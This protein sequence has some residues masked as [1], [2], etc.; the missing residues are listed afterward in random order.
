MSNEITRAPA[1]LSEQVRY[2][3]AV[4]KAG[5][6]P[7]AY[8]NRPADIIVAMGLGQ[9][10][11]LSP[12][13]SLYRINVINGK[14]TASAELIAAQVRKAGHRL[15]LK[16]DEKKVSVTCTIIR[17][18]DPE[19][20]FTA[21]RDKEWAHSMGLDRPDRNGN[22]SNY[23][24]QPMTMLT[25]RAI[26][27]CAREA[28]PEALYGVA[29]TSDEMHDLDPVRVEG[30]VEAVE[31]AS[32]A[33]VEP[34]A[35]EAPEERPGDVLDPIRRLITPFRKACG[36]DMD[37]AMDAVVTYAGVSTMEELAGNEPMVDEV[38]GYMEDVIAKA[39]GAA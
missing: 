23:V 15:R 32:E 34:D 35:Y 38:V 20:P 31:G 21:T 3:D 14:P 27:A 37:Q 11:G 16:K 8:Q 7:R 5:I 24:K 10:M 2:A 39:G 26:T 22:P 28:C 13:E 25:W 6:L 4:S 19:A 29:Y 17:A 12:M 33:P 9:S 18:D 36:F 1:S 30:T